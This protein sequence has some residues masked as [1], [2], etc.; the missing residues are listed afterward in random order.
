MIRN[1]LI[2]TVIA[3]LVPTAMSN[4]SASAGA[5]IALF[6][7]VSDSDGLSI[8]GNGDT[9]KMGLKA[10]NDNGKSN[11]VSDFQLTADNVLSIKVGDKVTLKD[12]V[13][14][15]KAVTTDARNNQKAIGITSNGMIDFAR[16]TQGVYTLDVVV[17]DD[18]AYEAII[19][20]GGQTQESVKSVNKEIT[21]EIYNGNNTGGNNTGGNNTGGNNTGG[22]NTG[23]GSRNITSG[24]SGSGSNMTIG[25]SG[26]GSNM[27]I[28]GSGSGGSNMTENGNF[29]SGGGD[30]GSNMTQGITQF[31]TVPE[32]VNS[33]IEDPQS[34]ECEQIRSQSCDALGCPGYP[35][36]EPEPEPEPVIGECFDG[37]TPV[38]GKCPNPTGEP[39]CQALGCPGSPPNPSPP[40]DEL[41]P[42]FREPELTDKNYMPGGGPIEPESEPIECGEGEELVDGQCVSLDSNPVEPIYYE[43]DDQAIIDEGDTDES[44]DEQQDEDESGGSEDEAEDEGSE[45]ESEGESEEES[46]G[47]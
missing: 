34:E 27:T 20:I 31:A 41:I 39:A 33:C 14:F 10:T 13:D 11:K 6:S 1:I 19:V 28:G 4:V 9:A 22:N 44:E 26:S 29:A 8:S 43:S 47:N 32:P 36:L 2:M 3:A 46:G 18:K 42:G 24:D 16:Y 17:D 45:Q 23:G 7:G 30:G 38:D 12:N 5:E 25:G 37:A 21:F 15:T 40:D 35:I